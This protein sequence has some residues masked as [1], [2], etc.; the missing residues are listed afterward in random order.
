MSLEEQRKAIIEDA[1]AAGFEIDNGSVF[2][3]DGFRVLDGMLAKFAQ[4]QAARNQSNNVPVAWMFEYMDGTLQRHIS[5]DYEAIKRNAE[6]HGC[7]LIP[8]V[9][10]TSPQQSNA[11]EMA[12]CKAKQSLEFIASITKDEQTELSSGW[13]DSRH[14]SLMGLRCYRNQVGQTAKSGLEAIRALIPQ[15]ES[16]GK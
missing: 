11:L 13:S 15:P 16:D 9:A 8:L 4:L 10:Y 2:W 1:K 3:S 6:H 14:R 5:K 7:Q 12:L